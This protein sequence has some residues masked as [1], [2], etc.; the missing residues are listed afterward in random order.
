MTGPIAYGYGRHSTSKQGKMSPEEQESR[1]YDYYED[2]L[3]P[4]GVE[5]GGWFYDDAVSGGKKFREREKGFHVFHALQ[6]GDYI[7]TD[8]QDRMFRN[9]ADGAA[10]TDVWE[11]EGINFR[12]LDIIM[13]DYMEY[14]DARRTRR[15][16]LV[17]A[18]WVI[19]KAR[20]RELKRVKY[21][22]D[23]WI[24]WG[25]G[26][27]PGWSQKIING[28]REFRVNTYERNVIDFM[29]SLKEDGLNHSQLAN[30]FNHEDRHGKFRGHKIRKM[31]T[32]AICSWMVRSW[33]ADFKVCCCDRMEFNRLWKAGKIPI[34][35]A[36]HLQSV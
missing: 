18:E 16:K 8:D 19:D 26:C 5:W 23:H 31:S 4:K 6:K 10:T 34:V 13:I 22:K 15:M 11:E 24:P 36:G 27:P 17:D 30:W 29:V 21:C 20:E 14:A 2:R 12:A 1:V 35:R 28:R 33:M 7:I 25:P 3:E 9:T 32:P